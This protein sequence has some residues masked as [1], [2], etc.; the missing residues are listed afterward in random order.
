MLGLEEGF[1][2]GISDEN[3]D[4][5]AGGIILG[6]SEVLVESLGLVLIDG[7][8][9]GNILGIV[10]GLSEGDAL[11]ITEIYVKMDRPHM[12]MDTPSLTCV[13]LYSP[14]YFIMLVSFYF[15]TYSQCTLPTYTIVEKIL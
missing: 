10:V 5:I 7:H 3:T 15:P 6:V 9:D 13:L 4:G 14:H 2:G 1:L 11:G 8:I 12:I